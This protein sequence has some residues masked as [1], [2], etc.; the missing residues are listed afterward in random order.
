MGTMEFLCNGILDFDSLDLFVE[1]RKRVAPSQS[2][3]ANAE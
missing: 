3:L 2:E 1:W